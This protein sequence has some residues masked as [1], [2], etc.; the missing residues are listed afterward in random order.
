MLRLAAAVMVGWGAAYCQP[1][2]LP[3]EF[4]TNTGQFASEVLYLARTSN[5]FV[6]L[7]HT[8]MTLGLT[9]AR[10][11]GATLRMTLVDANRH[12]STTGEARSAGVSN[13]LIGNDPA[14]W[15]RGVAHY[16]SVRYSGVWPGI[17]LLFHGRDQS[18]E[19]DFI[20]APHADPARIRMSW[21]NT[22]SLRVDPAGDLI[23]RTADGEIRQHRPEI[24]QVSAG[25]RHDIRGRYRMAGTR[26]VRFEVEAYDSQ[27]PL[28]IDPVLTYSTYLGGTGTTKLNAM[29]LDSSGNLY[30]TGRV[31]SPDFPIAGAARP[32]ASGMGLY[33]SQDRAANW[34]LSSSAVSTTKVLALATDPKSNSVAYAGTSRGVFKTTDAGVTWKPVAGLPNDAVTAIAVDANNG[35]AIFACMSEGLYQSTDGG[36]TWKSILAGP[37]SSVALAAT[38]AGVMYA[39]RTGA[40]ILRSLDGGVSWQEVGAGVIVTA[41]AVDPTN[42]FVIYAATARSGI[43]LSTD[44]GNN[45]TFSNTGMVS[46]A[47][48]LTVNTIAIDP[49]IPQRL[50]AAT[51]NGLFRSSDG[52]AGWAPAGTGIGAVPVLSLAINPQDANFVYAGTAGAG[53]FKSTDGGD[54][55]TSTGPANLDANAVAVDPTGLFLHAGLFVGTQGFVTKINA[56]G[57]ALVYSTYI[58]GSG[59]T[60]GRAIAVDST[61]RTYVCGATD[62]GDFPNRN[63][64]QT[65]IGRAQTWTIRVSLAAT[66]TTPAKTWRWTRPGTCTW[67]G[68]LTRGRPTRRRTI[69]RLRRAP[70]SA[71]ARAADRIASSANSTIPA[72]G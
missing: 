23:L 53:I 11:P 4:E 54:T 44:G 1:V 21:E 17:D 31:S 51:P 72:G 35:S 28:I 15:R 46:G 7:T 55:W 49:R 50:Y 34:V 45:W 8:S 20:V 68:T 56:S 19:Y 10:E 71:P 37:V 59:A 24:Y 12:A 38:K 3:L 57:S 58:G 65:S 9:N 40:P 2:A 26:E 39:G 42:S 69:F 18:L 43:Y 41:L 66:A 47:T 22:Q 70:S 30:M 62:A 63:A 27:L 48:P 5:H 33:R 52:G 14:R 32:Q 61:G 36:T 64:Y 16:G 25:V 29:T 13:Y 60:E 67:R 6:Y